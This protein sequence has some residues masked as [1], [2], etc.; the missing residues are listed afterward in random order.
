MQRT[1]ATQQRLYTG[2]HKKIEAVMAEFPMTFGVA[3][4]KHSRMTVRNCEVRDAS[5]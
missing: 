3:Q 5:Q 4:Y 1:P 2:Q